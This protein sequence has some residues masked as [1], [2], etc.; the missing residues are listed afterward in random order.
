MTIAVHVS[1]EA[2]KKIGGIGSV[3]HGLITAKNYQKKF[4][5]TLL[6]TPLF[7]HDADPHSKLGEGSTTLYSDIDGIDQDN[8][9]KVFSPIEKRHD[10][11]IIYGKKRFSKNGSKKPVAVDIIAIDI[12]S[13]NQQS[14]NSFKH[15]LW[16]NFGIQSDHYLHDMDYEQYLRIAI[17]HAEILEALYPKKTRAVIFSHEYMGMPTA[18]AS[19]I[20]RRN[21][22]RENDLT[23]F[24]AHEIF[25]A[26]LV[27]EAHQG[28]DLSFY[29]ILKMDR[30]EGISLEQEF[31]SHS[32]YARNELVKRVSELDF[33]FAVGDLV[34][35]EL[36][37]L[38]PNIDQNKIKIVYN[39][40]PID[41]VSYS[42]KEE[43]I[44]QIQ[45]YCEG[46]FNFRPDYIFTH[47]A[48]LVISKAMWRDTRL[49]YN[50][51]EHFAKIGKKGFFVILSTLIGDGRS[52]E[53][54]LKMESEYGWP[55][56]HK[57]GWPDLVGAEVDIYNQLNLFNARSKAIKGVFINQFGFAHNIAGKRIPPK[58]SLLDLRLASDI[59]FGLSIYEPFGIAQLETLP[60]G[61]IA[62]I[63][64][65]CG[66]ASL[67]KD[68]LDEGEYLVV[69]YTTVPDDFKDHLK[70]KYD[71][72]NISKEMRDLIETEICTKA[73][74]HI[75]SILP[76]H[77]RDRKK[78]FTSMQSKSLS[79]DWDHVV[80]RIALQLN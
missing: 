69:D 70:T 11:K 34:K 28:H 72:L 20:N 53:T 17:P 62:V 67:L 49:L 21:G 31:G 80:K 3:L 43:S 57:E 59:E 32:H 48:R 16:R 45:N 19:V 50:I 56:L 9:A 10:I 63:S 44:S 4:E 52:A 46:L 39:G 12:R 47:V 55:V 5:H 30:D 61:G 37:Y 22:Y 23:I 40:I 38:S 24:Y 14:I 66:C 18:L 41:T 33:V 76:K 7:Y 36:I 42:S 68:T 2:V 74:A 78:M 65:A 27:T 35:E 58:I 8:F 15:D 25:T 73:A 1:H 60:F 77:A 13:M 64:D 6:Y 29:N 75:V 54:I 79:L 26:R 51:D 71:F